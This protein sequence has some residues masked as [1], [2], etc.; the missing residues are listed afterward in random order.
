VG[1]NN[2]TEALG[3]WSRHKEAVALLLTD[4]VMPSGLTG[5]ELAHRLQ[6]DCPR[7]KIILTSGY[8]AEIANRG[9]ILHE[10]QI[11]L[12]KPYRPQELIEALRRCLDS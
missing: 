12:P 9:L 1:A 10:G 8:S 3:L 2:G 11:F 4:L 6:A 7:L 5:L